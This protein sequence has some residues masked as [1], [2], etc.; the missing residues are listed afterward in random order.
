MSALSLGSETSKA[1]TVRSEDV[2]RRI[3]ALLVK[4]QDVIGS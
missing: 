2:S 4:R 3:K 1:A